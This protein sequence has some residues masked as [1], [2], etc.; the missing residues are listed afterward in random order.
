MAHKLTNFT[1]G[2]Q[3]IGHFGFMFA[4]GIK[5]PLLL[6]AATFSGFIWWRLSV[7]LDD[8]QTYLCWMRIYAWIFDW[9]GFEPTKQVN[10]Q[11]ASGG[12]IVTPIATLP[13]H[14]LILAAWARLIVGIEQGST[15]AA[16][17]TV[18]CIAGFG[19]IATRFGRRAKESL[20]ERGAV[21]ATRSQLIVEIGTHNAVERTREYGQVLGRG[22][23]FTTKKE[24]R[25]AGLFEPYKI[26]GV[27]FPW[28]LEQSHAMIVGTT[29]TGKTVAM[30]DLLSQARARGDRAVVFDLTGAF[31]EA[32][33]DPT[34]DVILNPTD[35][36]C[37]QWSIFDDCPD[38]ATLTSAAE[39]LVPLE[40]G[41]SDSFWVLAARTLFI[42]MCLK[43]RDKG[44]ATNAALGSEL[45]TASLAHIH[46]FV[47]GTVAGP[48]TSPDAPRM[49]QS[50]HSI[51][52]TNGKALMALP[53]SGPSFSIRDWIGGSGKPG[54]FLFVSSRY[55]E[56]AVTSHLLTLWMDTAMMALMSGQRTR[57]LQVWFLFDELG[58]LHRMPALE[59]GLQTARNYGGAIVA[60]VHAYAKL[61]DTYGENMATTIASLTRTKL[62]LATADRDSAT[63]C[64]DF[65]GHGQLREMEEGYSYGA[66]N[67]RDAV[68]LTPRRYTVPLVL[69]DT[70]K[71]LPRLKG[72]L[73]FPDGFPAAPVKL[74]YVEYPSVAEPYI[75]RDIGEGRRRLSPPTEPSPTPGPAA[76]QPG[77]DQGRVP[78]SSDASQP[79]SRPPI[80]P[81]GTFLQT[82][83]PATRP[84]A[85]GNLPL[86]A[87]P[88]GGSANGPKALA[89]GAVV[90][91]HTP[92]SP[93]ITTGILAA[94]MPLTQLDPDAAKEAA[95]DR[96]RDHGA[97]TERNI[98]IDHAR[99]CH[100]REPAYER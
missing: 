10:L 58:A 22:W 90:A 92:M 94:A 16:L 32:F 44:L 24:R 63:W 51:L 61:K 91:S 50:I 67:A 36:R 79:T 65:I 46:E 87:L 76:A 17:I 49:A 69:P 80:D 15:I 68:S 14:P 19:W 77:D 62:V 3:L 26:A 4:A 47:V 2:S 7:L 40:S 60:G 97:V 6:T 54:S 55:A 28:R 73:K 72:Y 95:P 20:H 84:G 25:A 37:P 85:Q 48:L 38:E 43:L 31:I 12:Q 41:A 45:M 34:R 71:D 70:L 56:M 5:T 74:R 93:P 57:E 75:K 18:P 98:G 59:K 100:P 64:S 1:R 8:H 86:A 78:V 99:H 23:R 21:L 27:S 82:L 30:R 35:A 11:L 88:V 83:T 96:E 9:F 29:G 66:D 39:A 13:N 33:Y 89:A 52:T 42:E 53:T 81:I